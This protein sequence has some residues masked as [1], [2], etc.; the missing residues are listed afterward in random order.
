MR[1]LDAGAFALGALSAFGTGAFLLIG[2]PAGAWIDHRSRRRVMIGADVLRAAA[3]GSV[4]VAWAL[5]ALTLVQ[6]DLVALTTGCLTV[7]F[8][9]AYQ[10]YLSHLV[11]RA[12]LV[13]ANAKLTG[14][15]QVAGVAGPSVAETLV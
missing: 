6:L 3:L 8:D 12:H 14:S 7:L 13:E 4:P 5:G 9:V 1:A 15:A 2:L 10:S 11:G